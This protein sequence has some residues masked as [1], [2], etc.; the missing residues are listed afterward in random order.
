MICMLSSGDLLSHV[1]MQ[2]EDQRILLVGRADG[3]LGYLSPSGLE[4]SS[5]G[6]GQS[7]F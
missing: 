2:E 3:L 6:A 5:F 7:R 1:I 4:P